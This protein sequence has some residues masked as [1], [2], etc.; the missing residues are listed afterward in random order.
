[1]KLSVLY[2]F[3]CVYSFGIFAQ[4]APDSAIQIAIAET[5][6]TI[7]VPEFKLIDADTIVLGEND[8]M[9]CDSYTALG[10]PYVYD[11]LHSFNRRRMDN[12]GG[13][14]NVKINEGL[15]RIRSKGFQS[16]IKNLYIQID[17]LTLTVYWIAVVGPSEDGQCYACMDSRGSA[18]GG[19]RAVNGQLP[20]MHSQYPS[21]TPI[22]LND[23]NEN[24]IQ[25]YQGDGTPLSSYCS[26]V[27]IHQKFYK[28]ATD[29]VDEAS[30]SVIVKLNYNNVGAETL[31]KTGGDIS[32]V[33]K[34]PATTSTQRRYKVKSGDTLSVIARKYHTSVTTIKKI[35]HLKSDR[36]AIGQ[37]LRL[38]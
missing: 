37:I 19:E 5:K 36:I 25:C 23:F 15:E 29:C 12:F 4:E 32:L 11:A 1:M 26:Y 18:G 31:L 6:P 21:M 17:P 27:N 8:E 20:R 34:K 30:D 16:D 28:Y 33:V 9:I 13:Y 35:N 14:M 2:C 7:L 22:L 38:P 10:N 3:F 24:V